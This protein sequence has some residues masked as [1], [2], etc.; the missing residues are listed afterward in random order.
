M[1]WT[2]LN[3]DPATSDRNKVRFLTGDTNEGDQLLQDEEVDFLLAEQSDPDLA[4]VDAAEAIAAKFAR[5]ADTQNEGLAISASQRSK[6]Y[7]DIAKELRSRVDVRAEIFA[8]GL[9]VSGKDTMAD[10]TDAIQPAFKRGQDD[11]PG[12]N[13]DPNDQDTSDGSSTT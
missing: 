8:G 5:Q 12:T 13:L 10:D 9:T 6:A 1:T 4:A 11:L 2:Y 3:G 7:R